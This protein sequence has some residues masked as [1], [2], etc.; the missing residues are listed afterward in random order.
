MKKP[1]VLAAINGDDRQRLLTSAVHIV[2]EVDK[3]R[4]P[5]AFPAPHPW[6]S[7]RL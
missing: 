7:P 4:S 2:D 1:A 3:L 6:P 5:R